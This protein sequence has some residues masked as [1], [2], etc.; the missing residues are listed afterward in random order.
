MA[1]EQPQN[2]EAEE[3][4]LGSMLIE[5]E[6]IARISS[7]IEAKDFYI[8][9]NQWVCEAIYANGAN[10]DSLTVANSLVEAKRLEEIGGE[11]Y[12]T[13]LMTSVPTA[14]NVETYARIVADLATRRRLLSAL[15]ATAKAAYDISM[16]IDEVC[17]ISHQQL[18]SVYKTADRSGAT[19]PERSDEF[20]EWLNDDSPSEL[21][22]CGIKSFDAI[23]GGGFAC[24]EYVIVAAP[25]GV[26]KTAIAVQAMYLAAARG[27]NCMYFSFEVSW[28]DIACRMIA[29]KLSESGH[30]IHYGKIIKRDL[31]AQQRELCERAWFEM[32][33]KIK[34]R[35]KIHDPSSMTPDQ[36]RN[37]AIAYGAKHPLDMIVIDQMHH[38]S[39][40]RKGSDDR[41]RLSFISRELAKL[42][43][44]MREEIGRAHV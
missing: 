31:T 25:P 27:Q 17:G 6:C 23:V 43:K 32:C 13:R 36:I 40:G 29:M 21:I 18:N 3:A 34:S 30:E 37:A 10:A 7:I 19:L 9:R 5:P 24:G 44:I 16:P 22:P 38:M 26:G 28:K 20:I 39:D 11:S 8:V 33:D 1:S 14:L 35:I 42:P 15:T 12:L 2:A 41:S 4:V